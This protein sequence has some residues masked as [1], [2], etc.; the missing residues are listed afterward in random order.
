MAANLSEAA[1]AANARIHPTRDLAHWIAGIDDG[2]ITAS[3]LTWAK[4]TLLDWLGVTIA[5]AREPLSDI[6]VADI[7][8]EGGA[9]SNH[10]P[11]RPE[12]VIPSQAALI[13]GTASHALD[14]D[15]VHMRMHGHPSA[16][17]LPAILALA[18]QRDA[19]GRD[20][21]KAFI[22][23][24]EVECLIGEMMGDSHYEDGW[25]NTATIGTFGAAAGCA[26][27]LDLDSEK[28]A[29]ALGIAA[30]Q[31]AGLKSMFGT[32][33]KPLHAGKA[34]FNG[35]LAARLAGR[36]FTSRD[37]ALECAQGFADTQSR[38]YRAL[39]VRP[40]TDAAFAI[41]ANL[42]KYHAACYLTH[43][44]IE[45]VT[46]LR[47]EH[48]LTAGDVAG[49]RLKVSPGH[50]KVCNIPSPRT[51]LEIK[52]SLRHTA[53][54]ALLGENTGALSTYSDAMANRP[55]LIELREKVGIETQPFPQRTGAEVIIELN[56]GR[57]LQQAFDVGIPAADLDDQWRR[58]TNKFRSIVEPVLGAEKTA[59]CIEQ[60]SRLDEAVSLSA[61]LTNTSLLE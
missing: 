36:G 24:Y 59:I 27:L 4:H 60:C 29:M 2:A 6:L 53:A 46:A 10:L 19:H 30:T 50:L 61:L 26:K 42:F 56:D 51:G 44:P 49:I 32:M 52:F 13:N 45:A 35:L 25:H 17:V 54:L 40:D 39:P 7:M 57:H 38:D 11:G 28:T 1:C 3:A 34:A 21:L 33:C 58:L 23:G 15:D 14:Y 47:R 12:R 22:V 43:S 18:E 8:A 20:L 55:D 5:G 37:D 48:H 41:E 16:P 31:A 9:G